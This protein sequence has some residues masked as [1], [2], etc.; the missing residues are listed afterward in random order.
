MFAGF[1]SVSIIKFSVTTAALLFERRLKVGLSKKQLINFVN[2]S[3]GEVAFLMT[4]F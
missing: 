4:W 2:V 3:Q 1:F